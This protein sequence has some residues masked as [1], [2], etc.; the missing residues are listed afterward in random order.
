MNQLI[1]QKSQHESRFLRNNYYNINKIQT[2]MINYDFV[3][4][5]NYDDNN[6]YN[7]QTKLNLNKPNITKPN[8]KYIQSA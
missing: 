1:L 8:L 3:Y 6:N 7:I 4:D 5:N 2:A